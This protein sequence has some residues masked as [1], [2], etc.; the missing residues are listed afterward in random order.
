MIVLLDRLIGVRGQGEKIALEMGF[1]DSQE[2]TEANSRVSVTEA[3]IHGRKT[4]RK[5]SKIKSPHL[6]LYITTHQYKTSNS[7]K[8]AILCVCL[9][10]LM[11]LLAGMPI[12]PILDMT[13]TAQVSRCT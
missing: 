6:P 10:A 12:V 2:V 9:Q 1:E 11:D 4:R 8:E 7:Q 13:Y 3:E 5:R